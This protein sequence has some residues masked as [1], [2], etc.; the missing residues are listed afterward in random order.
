MSGRIIAIGDIHG[1]LPALETVLAA[2]AP[3]A[4]D[5]I[6]TLGDYVDRGPDSPGVID[7]LIALEKQCHL[8]PLLGNHDELLLKFCEGQPATM[9]WEDWLAFG[10]QATVASYGA[11][12]AGVP[13]AHVDFLR[14]CRLIFETETHFFVHASYREDLPL[15]QQPPEVLVWDRIKWRL[16]GPHFSGKVAVIGHNAQKTGVVLDLGYLKCID[17]FCYGFGYLTAMDVHNGQL[18]QADKYGTRCQ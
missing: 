13:A 17:T 6:V 14:R 4:D 15:D 18:W 3:Q 10:G 9:S 8:V 7:R 16:P 5:T 11:V 1:W 2:V 12:P